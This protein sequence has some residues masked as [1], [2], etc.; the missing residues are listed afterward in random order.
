MGLLR[1]RFW[2]PACGG[3]GT[4]SHGASLRAIGCSVAAGLRV[5]EH[6][7]L[8]EV[9]EDL[10]AADLDVRPRRAPVHTALL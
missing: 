2:S 4:S 1:S 6:R 10:E 8:D 7:L 3:T 9:E 5:L